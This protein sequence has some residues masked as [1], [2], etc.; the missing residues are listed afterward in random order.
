MIWFSELAYIFLPLLSKEYVSLT[1]S[2]HSRQSISQ[3]G[4]LRLVRL[5]TTCLHYQLFRGDV[6]R[7]C[8]EVARHVS[9]EVA[10]KFLHWLQRKTF[11][12]VLPRQSI[13]QLRL[14]RLG[15]P[16]LITSSFG[17]ILYLGLVGRLQDMF[18]QREVAYKFFHWI[19]KNMSFTFL[20]F[21][22]KHYFP[23]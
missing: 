19:P 18:F 11:V 22:A 17:Q 8:W 4:S 9:S 12:T 10:Y 23:T 5:R 7:I 15:R 13:S 16:N 14:V 6:S 21:K 1:H 2:W 3:L 20:N